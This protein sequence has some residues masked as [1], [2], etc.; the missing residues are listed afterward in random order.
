MLQFLSTAFS[1]KGL[2]S[3]SVLTHPWYIGLDGD[4]NKIHLTYNSV[5]PPPFSD[6]LMMINDVCIEGVLVAYDLIYLYSVH[7]W[8]AH[9]NL[10][11]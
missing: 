5:M 9:L 10:C 1:F 6:L 2:L 3:F 11:L 7:K 4:R 8:H